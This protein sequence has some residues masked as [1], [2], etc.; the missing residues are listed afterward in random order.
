MSDGISCTEDELFRFEGNGGIV[1]EFLGLF[2]LFYAMMLLTD[3]YLMGK[4]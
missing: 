2:V 4:G 3:D 1:L